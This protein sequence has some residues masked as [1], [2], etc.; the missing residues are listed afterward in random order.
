[1]RRGMFRNTRSTNNL[2]LGYIL[3]LG[4]AGIRH[5]Q[6]SF[7]ISDEGMHVSLSEAIEQVATRDLLRME[8]GRV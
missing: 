6:V 4:E 3:R 7:T 5:V 2:R 1:M 8:F